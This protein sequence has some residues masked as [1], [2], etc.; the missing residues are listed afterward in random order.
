MHKLIKTFS[1]AVNFQSIIWI[2]QR[3][4][5][6]ERFF[7][8]IITMLFSVHL[9]QNEILM[10][11]YSRYKFGFNLNRHRSRAHILHYHQHHDYRIIKINSIHSIKYFRS[12]HSKSYNCF[13]IF[14]SPKVHRYW[15]PME[16]R[17][18]HRYHVFLASGSEKGLSLAMPALRWNELGDY[19][20]L[21]HPTTDI[22]SQS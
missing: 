12:N 17:R 22:R 8:I 16:Q 13:V 7:R 19:I 6:N 4:H 3:F 21:C 11:S 18:Y 2:H 14:L 10:I 20:A 9:S 15:M 5:S 1:V